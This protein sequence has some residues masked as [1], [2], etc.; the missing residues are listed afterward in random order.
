[1]I[2]RPLSHPR[3]F[4]QGLSVLLLLLLLV[5]GCPQAT[6]TGTTIKPPIPPVPG[7]V[8]SLQ[9]A[10]KIFDEAVQSDQPTVEV[11]AAARAKYQQV[12]EIVETDLQGK[13]SQPLEVNAY[14]LLAFSQWR[15]GNYARA[16]TAE[17]TGRQLYEKNK[18]TTNKRDYGMLLIV[19]GLSAAAQ[20]YKDYRNSQTAITKERARELTGKLEMDMRDIDSS[21]RY[22]GRQEPIMVYAHLWQLALV[23]AAVRIWTG[24]PKEVSRPQV[25]HWLDRAEPVFAKIPET[26]N[27]WQNLTMVYK[28]KF[29][30][31]KQ[32][33]C[34]G[35]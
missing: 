19:G 17:A 25:C 14:A 27:P 10:Q 35:L 15:L 30:Q 18:L 1:M 26:G 31:K 8:G 23:D 3:P 13:V 24:L 6:G 28:N 22:L 11:P 7:P 9:Q 21:D 32:A 16:M 2:R 12:V 29:A 33:D 34:R 20:T 4:Y 5:T